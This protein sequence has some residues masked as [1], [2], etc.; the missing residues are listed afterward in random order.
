MALLA[1]LQ[2]RGLEDYFEARGCGVRI[3]VKALLWSHANLYWIW[4][5]SGFGFHQQLT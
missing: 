5:R 1:H 4:L 3:D 2:N